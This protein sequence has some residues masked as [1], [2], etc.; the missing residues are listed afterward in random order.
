MIIK[1]HYNKLLE[2]KVQRGFRGYPIVNLFMHGPNDKIATKIIA[3]ITFKKSDGV[4][5]FEKWFSKDIDIRQNEIVMQQVVNF[6][7]L[8]SVRTVV[9]NKEIVGCPHEEG[10]D[11]EKGQDCSFCPFWKDK[12]KGV[13]LAQEELW[14][15]SQ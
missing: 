11:Y 14:L 2:R 1:A 5:I 12:I 10:I 3:E 9:M 4:V 6:V 7:K 8:H 15:V 13:Y